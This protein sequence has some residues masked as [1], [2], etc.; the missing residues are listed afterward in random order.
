MG[1]FN[2]RARGIEV[3]PE[4]YQDAL[5]F[6]GRNRCYEGKK[7]GSSPKKGGWRPFRGK[8]LFIASRLKPQTRKPLPLPNGKD[9][10]STWTPKVGKIIAQ[11][12]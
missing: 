2:I 10:K 1:V 3:F 8:S 7:Y 9:L 11:T 4:L 12:H 6:F 5:M